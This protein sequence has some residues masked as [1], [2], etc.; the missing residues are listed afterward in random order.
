M[1]EVFQDLKIGRINE[2]EKTERL[3]TL[4]GVPDGKFILHAQREGEQQNASK[5]LWFLWE[6]QQYVSHPKGH[7]E[8]KP[9]RFVARANEADR[10]AADRE[11]PTS[12]EM[13]L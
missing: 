8:H 4:N 3:N 12:E 13:G 6:C 7:D 9:W 2:Q 5:Y 11:L 10:L 1:S